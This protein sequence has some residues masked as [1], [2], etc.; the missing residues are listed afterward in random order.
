MHVNVLPGSRSVVTLLRTGLH[1]YKSAH[2]PDSVVLTAVTVE[3]AWCRVTVVWK[4]ARSCGLLQQQERDTQTATHS[5]QPRMPS[6]RDHMI[7][8]APSSCVTASS[9]TCE[10]SSLNCG[11]HTD[12]R[13]PLS[14][15]FTL[16]CFYHFLVTFAWP[17]HLHV[18]LITVGCGSNCTCGIK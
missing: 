18:F 8:Q 1:S 9:H 11:A 5:V 16:L 7:I 14:C 6:F 2:T 4:L 17:A 3:T 13:P 12:P 10:E 15:P